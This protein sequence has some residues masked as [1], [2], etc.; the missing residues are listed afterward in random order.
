MEITKKKTRA[1]KVSTRQIE[2]LVTYMQNHAAFATNKLL[3]ARGKVVHDKQWQDLTEKLN[4]IEG[5][6]KTVENWKKVCKK[7]N[8]I[9]HIFLHIFTFLN[10]ILSYIMFFLFLK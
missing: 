1:P 7:C 3:G 4:S 9:L 10:V 2:Y 8:Y 5:P 6:T